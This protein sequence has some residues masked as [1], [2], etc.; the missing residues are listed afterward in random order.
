MLSLEKIRAALP[1]ATTDDALLADM[2]ARAV[3]FIESQTA[4]YFGPPI[5]AAEVVL[6]RGTYHLQLSELARLDS[7]TTIESVDERAY[8]GQTATVIGEDGFEIREQKNRTYLVRHG[9]YKWTLGYEYEVT[10]ERGY[11]EDAGP[12]DIEQLILDLLALRFS[13]QGR[14]GLRSETIGGYSYTR[15]GEGDF[16]SI[17]GSWPTIKAWREPVFA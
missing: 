4:R 16:D 1:N 8:P 3:A 10:Y 14:E 11:D 15:F 6:G 13:M 2:E 9:G 12:K 17:D 7:D 5:I